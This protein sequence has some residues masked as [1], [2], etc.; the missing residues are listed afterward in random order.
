MMNTFLNLAGFGMKAWEAGRDPR[1]VRP[2][3]VPARRRDARHRPPVR[4]PL[5]RARGRVHRARRR[6]AD[7]GERSPRSPIIA[8][9]PLTTDFSTW[10]EAPE[11][12]M[13]TAVLTPDGVEFETRDLDV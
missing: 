8:S 9:E 10:L 4:E 7:D 2:R 1:L 6:L 5:L 11:Y 3:L 12:S 13:L